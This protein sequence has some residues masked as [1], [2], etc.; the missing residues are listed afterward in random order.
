MMNAPPPPYVGQGYSEYPNADNKMDQRRQ[1]N[2][3]DS[4]QPPPQSGH[5]APPPVN[6]MGQTPKSYHPPPPSMMGK[7]GHMPPHHPLPQ[8]PLPP[9][10]QQQQHQ[11]QSHNSG[12]FYPSAGNGPLHHHAAAKQRDYREK[13]HNSNSGIANGGRMGHIPPHGVA[14]SHQQPPASAYGNGNRSNMHTP[15]P[16]NPAMPSS[17]NSNGSATI[18][19]GYH[20]GSPF[21]FNRSEAQELFKILGSSNAAELAQFASMAGAVQDKFVRS[22]SLLADDDLV[23]S[24]NDY[25]TAGSA[26]GAKF[27]PISRMNN[28]PLGGG[29]GPGKQRG[30]FPFANSLLDADWLQNLQHH[31][32]NDSLGEQSSSNCSSTSSSFYQNSHQQQQLPVINTSKQHEPNNNTLDLDLFQVD[33]KLADF[34]TG[35]GGSGTDNQS[36]VTSQLLHH[37]QQQQQQQTPQQQQHPHHSMAAAA[38]A[39]LSSHHH[40]HQQ[41]QQFAQQHA[42]LQQQ[43]QHVMHKLQSALADPTV[44]RFSDL[45]VNGGGV[46]SSELKIHSLKDLKAQ[47]TMSSSGMSPIVVPSSSSSSSSGGVVGVGGVGVSG[48]LPVGSG[49]PS[50]SSS[51]VV[52]STPMW[53]N[54]FDLSGMKQQRQEGDLI[55]TSST[56]SGNLSGSNAGGGLNSSTA[57]S[58]M[59]NSHNNNNNNEDSYEAGI[60]DDM[61]E[62]ALRLESELNIN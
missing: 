40:H 53:N 42:A 3:W 61:R 12:K 1:F 46:Q 37:H 5:P 33:R 16:Q 47:Q 24:E 15:L 35:G 31:M 49:S 41:Q 23:I 58:S 19:N 6:M 62:L 11:Q 28:N 57:S 7:V 22:D 39:L 21:P 48:G 25:S 8:Q 17:Q 14:H 29:G 30:D 54:L 38:V 13:H 50:S 44:Q 60:A 26:T 59:S 4:Q 9:P 27:G 34:G 56:D 18:M 10:P 52:T 55:G 2:P 43:Q 51:V 32:Y 20:G 45:M 36:N